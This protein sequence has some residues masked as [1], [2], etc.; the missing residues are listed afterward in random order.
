M[1]QVFPSVFV[2]SDADGFCGRARDRLTRRREGAKQREGNLS[3][4]LPFRGGNFASPGASWIQS[5][6]RRRTGLSFSSRLRV[7]LSF[8]FS[9]AS[10][11]WRGFPESCGLA[12]AKS[13]SI[14]VFLLLHSALREAR[15]LSTRRRSISTIS[16]RQSSNSTMSATAGTRPSR[17]IRKPP[18]V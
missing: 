11:S 14:S 10:G 12:P 2:F 5:K 17:A 1:F 15:T 8:V 3:S 18:R 6:T 9:D 16:K 4:R 7:R 13:G